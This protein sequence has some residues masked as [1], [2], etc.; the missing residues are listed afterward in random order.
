VASDQCSVAGCQSLRL[1]AQA[2]SVVKPLRQAADR[3]SPT[4]IIGQDPAAASNVDYCTFAV[5]Q[6]WQHE[7][8]AKRRKPKPFRAVETVKAMAR[9]RIGTPPASRVVPDKKKEQ[10]SAEKH[11]PT[12]GRVLGQDDLVS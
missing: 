11:K 12:L 1:T 10:E 4:A 8:V 7:Y 2:G 5:R 9:E 3:P 6:L